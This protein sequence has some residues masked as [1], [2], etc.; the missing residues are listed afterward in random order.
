MTRNHS[1]NLDNESQIDF[2]ESAV[3][4]YPDANLFY[5]AAI[6]TIWEDWDSAEKTERYIAN[7]NRRE[8][9][10]SEVASVVQ[11][12]VTI[13]PIDGPPSVSLP[14][15]AWSFRDDWNIKEFVWREDGMW[16]MLS[17]ETSA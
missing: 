12:S 14:D 4:D 2:L 16:R 9:T 15:D 6:K 10:G 17:W 1:D 13:T 3:E 11:E 5:A 8:R 7:S